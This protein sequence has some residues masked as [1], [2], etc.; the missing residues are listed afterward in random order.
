VDTG[1]KIAIAG[2]A[3][4]LAVT[5][6]TPAGAQPSPDAPDTANQGVFKTVTLIT[7]D[8]VLVTTA[9]TGQ[10][11]HF[12]RPAAGRERMNFISYVANGRL[13][14]VPAD[15]RQLIAADRLDRRLFDVTTLIESG[16]DDAS[17]DSLPLI[18]THEGA[19]RATVAT[20]SATRDLPSINAT[21]IAAGKS[22]ATAVWNSLTTGGPATR[23]TTAG[24]R[25]VWLDG[26]RQSILDRSTAQ[27]GAPAAWEAG[28]TG[29][30]QTIA[31]LD[32]GVDQTHPD[33]A[34]QEI[35][36]QNFSDA[37]DTVD[38]FGHGTHVASIAAGT[39][40]KADG[41][42]RGVAH[43]AKVLDAKVLNDFG[44]GLESWIIA[45]MEW[46][47]EQ[48]ATVANL[49]LGGADSAELDPLEE[50]VNNLSARH[51]ILFVIAAGNSGQPETVASPGSA[52]A[53]LTVGAVNR[54][55]SIA[56]FSSRG[57]RT[58]D[59]A[60]KPDITA[61]GV[62]IVA[63]A[64][65]E[66]LIGT[67]VEDGYVSLSGTSMATPHVAGAAA[68]L[69][70]R[71]PDWTG[72]QLKAALTAS[73]KPNPSLT[74]FDQGSGR[75]DLVRALTQTVTTEPTNVSLG[76]QLW[77]HHDDEPVTKPVTY[78]NAGGSDVTLN[79]S[80]RATGP[81]GRPAPDG[82]FTLSAN[83]ITV[84]AGGQA[85]VS[86]TGDT[87]VGTLD[88]AYSG[89]IVATAGEA[90]VITPV[91]VTREVESYTLTVD[92]RGADGAPT[93]DYQLA[94]IGYADG[95]L[96]FPYDQDGSVS[97]RLPK[98]LYLVDATIA[99]TSAGGDPHLS[100]LT[101][102]GTNVDG[103]TTVELAAATARPINVTLPEPATLELADIGLEV[104][105]ERFRLAKAVTTPDLSTVSIAQAGPAVAPDRLISRISTHWTT[106]SGAYYGLPWFHLGTVPN[107]LDKV[108]RRRDL[109]T[110]HADLG[111]VAPGRVG[112]RFVSPRPAGVDAIAFSVL[113]E[114]PLPSRRTE[115]YLAEGTEWASGLLQ[116]ASPT[117]VES[118]QT[119]AYRSF[120]AGR[121]HELRFNYATFG[122]SFRPVG[123]PWA[124]RVGDVI[125]V[126]LPL[127]G[128][129]SGN[130]G[131]SVVDSASTKLFRNGQLVGETT[132]PGIGVF[133]VPPEVSDYTLTTGAVRPQIFD[134]TTKVN[135]TWTFRSGNVGD[136]LSP[137][138]LSA[139]RFTPRLDATNSAPAGT[140]YLV[141]VT[142]QSQSGAT[143]RPRRLDVEV[144]YDEGRTWR[145]ADV[146]LGLAV[147]LHHPHDATSVSLR[148]KATDRD[149]NTVD[150]TII[151][152]YKLARR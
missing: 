38:R 79:L 50:A 118:E 107:G 116:M 55:D 69:A 71:H 16:Y 147:L 29:T 120:R 45:G 43:G 98:G 91:A 68:V 83:Q 5:T 123:V 84:P 151:R 65:A 72:E 93:A 100:L 77:P 36:E 101:S 67:P 87:R 35:A 82:M 51:G 134:V 99:G 1:K 7:G 64:A 41:K 57:P 146:I 40:A 122:P 19:A 49:S 136:G 12:V 59:G 114:V 110:V 9:R 111:T 74:A 133:E 95:R 33:L 46:A 17:R 129:S 124:L 39:G 4:A 6:M 63:A 152:A 94:V 130:A 142:V 11:T 119:S 131:F 149:G 20:A 97:A 128:D 78:R 32:T 25:K 44:G 105:T 48:G 42:Y 10:P 126:F 13:H 89:A 125:D 143:T 66:G 117:E 113:R 54:D 132:N 56:P 31:V 26:K 76:T 15:A 27:I 104:R 34:G 127:F 61:P 115:Y 106:A 103:D 37:E 14:V 137:L 62:S 24:V 108:V 70:Q 96:L 102:P 139:V 52:D 30:G 148:A 109:A 85:Q 92:V 23:A 80:L 28:Y 58:G 112:G 141:P 86:V 18:V 8:R 53:A 121:T 22:D 21:A 145:R 81:D 150:Q 75:V 144:S 135:A 2:T 60:I 73:A 140:P 88:G 47:A 138:P 90:S 3:L